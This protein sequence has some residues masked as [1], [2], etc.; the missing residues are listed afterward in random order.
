MIR[1]SGFIMAV[2]L[3][4][5][6]QPENN[7]CH[8]REPANKLIGTWVCTNMSSELGRIRLEYTFGKRGVFRWALIPV[9]E[10]GKS[11]PSRGEG[12]RLKDVYRLKG[13]KVIFKRDMK[14]KGDNRYHFALRGKRLILT[15]SNGQSKEILRLSR[16]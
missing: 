2:L 8:K 4:G 14:G 10:S 7:T 9:D 15:V 16:K 12:F 6:D 13:N 11:Q 1:V 3:I 5:A